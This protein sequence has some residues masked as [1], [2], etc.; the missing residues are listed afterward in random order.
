MI[1]SVRQQLVKL[2]LESIDE[3]EVERVK[4]VQRGDRRALSSIGDPAQ[5]RQ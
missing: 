1:A 3:A 4:T 5:R 2:A